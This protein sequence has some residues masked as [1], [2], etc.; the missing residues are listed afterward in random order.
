MFFLSIPNL[1]TSTCGKKR[2]NNL[3]PNLKFEQDRQILGRVIAASLSELIQSQEWPTRNF[4]LHYWKERLWKKIKFSGLNNKKS[5][6]NIA[7][8]IDIW[9]LGR[10][11]LE[12][13]FCYDVRSIFSNSK[14][15]PIS[16]T[17]FPIRVIMLER[18]G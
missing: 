8:T 2:A 18:L 15:W 1:V 5:I 7:Q 17:Q 16:S 11:W 14:M 6:P 13:C 10:E 12:M 4:S 3:G 9:I